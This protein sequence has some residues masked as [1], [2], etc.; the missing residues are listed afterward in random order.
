MWVCASRSH[1]FNESPRLG[2]WLH[3]L[4][5]IIKCVK[6]DVIE[7]YIG[8]VY[9]HILNILLP[10]KSVCKHVCTNVAAIFVARSASLYK[11]ITRVRSIFVMAW[12]IT[13]GL[14]EL[15]CT[16][17][18]GGFVTWRQHGA[19]WLRIIIGWVMSL[20]YTVWLLPNTDRNRYVRGKKYFSK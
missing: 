5:H 14:C 1:G 10:S 11:L 9:H 17:C 3:N 2:N 7:N 15:S 6:Y 13:L 20:S 12:E 19:V 16:A 4:V 8:I 18:S